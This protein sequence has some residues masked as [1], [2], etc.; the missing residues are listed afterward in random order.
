[1]TDWADEMAEELMLDAV[2]YKYADS[3]ALIAAKLRHL[4]AR[5]EVVAAN[6]IMD[7]IRPE[8]QREEAAHGTE[9]TATKS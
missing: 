8:A 7:I 4:K 1:M 6:T 2:R 5:G 9:T 3:R